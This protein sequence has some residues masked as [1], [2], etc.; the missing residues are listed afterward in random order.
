MIRR[1]PI[2]AVTLD[3][4]NTLVFH[5]T[6]E[7][8]GRVLMEYLEDQGFTPAPWE[9]QVLYDVFELHDEAYSPTAPETERDAYYVALAQRVL[10]RTGT[11]ASA[12][13]AARHAEALWR[14]LGPAS[15]AVFPD[16]PAALHELRAQ[17]V[18][19]AVISNWQRG[20]RHF[21][22]ELEISD[23]FEHILGSADLGV[24]KPDERIFREACGRLGVPPDR[25]LHVG[26]T[27][28]DDYLGGRAAGV[29]V[30]LIDRRDAGD[31]GAE[32]VITSLSELPGLVRE[33]QGQR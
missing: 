16:A 1:G 11:G 9:H 26:D 29:E 18:P 19:L 31:P 15:F 21:C 5:R 12:T 28:V 22:Q 14:I 25:V 24:A 23:F 32:R 17:G 4:Y 6:G 13:D 27:L 30:A 10:S 3:Y 33:L 20:L 2:E 8:R 7:G